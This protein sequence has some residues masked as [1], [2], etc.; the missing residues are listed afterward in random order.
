VLQHLTQWFAVK[1]ESD[2]RVF[3]FLQGLGIFSPPCP[4]RHLG[5]PS[6]LSSGYQGLFPWGWSG[7]GL[8]LTTHFLLVPRSIMRGAIPLFSQYVLMAWYLVKN[9]NN[10][11]T[12]LVEGYWGIVLPFDPVC[13]AV[14]VREATGEMRQEWNMECM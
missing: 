1:L 12:W 6:L 5:P 7:R 3:E 14:K 4:D 13:M 9:K 11:F 10:K 2:D 8:K